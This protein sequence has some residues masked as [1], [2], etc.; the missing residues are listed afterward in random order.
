MPAAFLSALPIAI[1]VGLL[2]ALTWGL[3]AGGRACLQHVVLRSLLVLNGQVPRHYVRF[4]DWAVDRNILRRVGGGYIFIHQLLLEHLALH[5]ALVEMPA[6]HARPAPGEDEERRSREILLERER[7]RWTESAQES[8]LPE[9][10]TIEPGLRWKPE[11][12]NAAALPAVRRR[13]V[14]SILGEAGGTLLVLGA[15]GSG[16]THLLLTLA[17]DLL[18]AAEAEPQRPVPVVLDLS[19][20]EE[21]HR[22]LEDWLIEELGQRCQVPPETA[23]RWVRDERVVPLLDGLDEVREH[24]REACVEAINAFRADHL[25]LPVA[26]CCRSREY[27]GASDRLRL[28]SAVEVQPLERAQIE[29]QLAAIG[30]CAEGLRAA[31]VRDPGLSE[32]L[33]S[34]LLLG[35]AASLGDRAI[36]SVSAEGTPEERQARLI[37]AYV[38]ALFDQ[39]REGPLYPGRSALRWLAW[40]ARML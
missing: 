17:R 12:V 5:Q 32:V 33:A 1:S 25:S 24:G 15:P 16:K 29:R 6:P 30:S 3:L 20:W 40:L 11:A 7:T 27:A 26:V 10:T 8:S 21:R 34:P 2:G 23:G 36:A 9:L 37:E 31:L 38:E 19:S 22:S 35:I 28:Q 39:P 14:P 4:L 13:D 18:A